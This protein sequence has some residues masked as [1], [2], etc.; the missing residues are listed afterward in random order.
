MNVVGFTLL[1]RKN[2]ERSFDSIQAK[3]VGVVFKT[4]SCQ[5]S[6]YLNILFADEFKYCSLLLR[7]TLLTFYCRCCLIII[8]VVCSFGVTAVQRSIYIS[9]CVDE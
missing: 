8:K 5:H 2:L 9:K 7:D 3:K 6:P 1:F 4:Q